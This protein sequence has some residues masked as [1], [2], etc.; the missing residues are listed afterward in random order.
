MLLF[1]VRVPA[2]LPTGWTCGRKL[3]H[4]CILEGRER[5]VAAGDCGGTIEKKSASQ[6]ATRRVSGIF[7]SSSNLPRDLFILDLYFFFLALVCPSAF[8]I[9]KRGRAGRSVD[10][11]RRSSLTGKRSRGQE[12]TEMVEDN[13][14]GTKNCEDDESRRGQRG[15]V[16]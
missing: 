8:E 10:A 1:F 3:G 11:E 5:R 13:K 16:W 2:Y 9:W 7:S 15:V 4:V 6:N 12:S 14:D